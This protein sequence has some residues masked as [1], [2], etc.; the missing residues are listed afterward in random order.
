LPKI[1]AYSHALRVLHLPFA[2]AGISSM[3]LVMC[4]AVGGVNEEM[5][6]RIDQRLVHAHSTTVA[7]TVGMTAGSFGDLS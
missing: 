2:V 1:F 3:S 5:S 4:L 7:L 6:R